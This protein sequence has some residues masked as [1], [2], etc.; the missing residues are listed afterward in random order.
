MLVMPC[1][2]IST[3]PSR[4]LTRAVHYL[5]ALQPPLRYN[6]IPSGWYGLKWKQATCADRGYLTGRYPRTNMRM[7]LV[8]LVTSVCEAHVHTVRVGYCRLLGKLTTQVSGLASGD[9]RHAGLRDT[10]HLSSSTVK[11]QE[12]DK[13]TLPCRATLCTGASPAMMS[14][15]LQLPHGERRSEQSP[16]I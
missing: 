4:Q 6:L 12:F 16:P 15:T 9:R 11:R 13:D 7:Y 14:A 3:Q 8:A 2:R 1:T 5:E 10:P